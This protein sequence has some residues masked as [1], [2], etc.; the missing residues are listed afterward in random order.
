MNI[1]LEGPDN[2]G[3]TTLA[4]W[5]SARLQLPYIKSPG[6]IVDEL[7]MANRM[8]RFMS[9]P[10]TIYDRF[11]A[12]SE[13]LFGSAYGRPS[14]RIDHM[15]ELF[16]ELEPVVIYCR[17]IDRTLGTHNPDSATDTPDYLAWLEVHHAALCQAYDDWA[18][19]HQVIHFAIGMPYEDVLRQISAAVGTRE[20]HYENA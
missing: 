20:K 5:L 13:P 10:A 9:A 12:I 4:K 14:F 18:R 15:V 19:L 7:D 8:L 1:V 6:P 3:K 17:S 16:Y 11:A 2:T